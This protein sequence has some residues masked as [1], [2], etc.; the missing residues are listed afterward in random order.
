MRHKKINCEFQKRIQPTDTQHNHNTLL[1][2]SQVV[3]TINK[4]LSDTKLRKNS[5]H[6]SVINLRPE[7]DTNLVDNSKILEK[8]QVIH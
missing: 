3:L 4:L 5:K 2:I 1:I 8:I 6:S 7:K